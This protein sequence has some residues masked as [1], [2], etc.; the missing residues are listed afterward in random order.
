MVGEEVVVGKV[1]AVS[2]RVSALP[3]NLIA[4][5]PYRITRGGAGGLLSLLSVHTERRAGEDLLGGAM[6]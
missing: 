1:V 6:I 3:K 2:S 4:P 5:L